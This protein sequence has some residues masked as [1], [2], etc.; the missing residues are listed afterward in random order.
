MLIVLPIFLFLVGLVLLSSYLRMDVTVAG[1][2]VYGQTS[3]RT[4]RT[5]PIKNSV[6]GLVNEKDISELKNSQEARFTIQGNRKL[7]SAIKGKIVK[8]SGSP[9]I[10]HSQTYYGIVVK[11]N[12]SNKEINLL[13]T[14]MNGKLSVVTGTETYFQ[15]LKDNI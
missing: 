8:I 11:L 3:Q 5:E 12:S 7:A 15:Y 9:Q 14:G 10:I 13:K 1:A 2:G 4:T 6:Y